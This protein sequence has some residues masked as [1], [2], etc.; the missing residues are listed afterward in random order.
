[1]TTDDL[2]SCGWCEDLAEVFDQF[3][4]EYLDDFGGVTQNLGGPIHIGRQSA[5]LRR[6]TSPY[7][8][9]TDMK[10]PRKFGGRKNQG[11]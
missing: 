4:L 7:G 11:G 10:S 6:D 8:S 2:I 3:P 1:M 9:M 5:K